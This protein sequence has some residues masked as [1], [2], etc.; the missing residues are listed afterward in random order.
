MRLSLDIAPESILSAAPYVQ[1]KTRR[2]GAC[3]VDLLIQTKHT[4]YVCE[5]KFRKHIDAGVIDD[6]QRKIASLPSRNRSSIRPVLIYGGELAPG[7]KRSDAFCRL[8]PMAD[9]LSTP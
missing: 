5:V 7:I 6:V 4:L 8:I 9:L 2:H 1:R 3:Q